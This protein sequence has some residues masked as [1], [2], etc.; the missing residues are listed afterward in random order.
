[1]VS[2][3]ITMIYA[4]GDADG[5]SSSKENASAKTRKIINNDFKTY[6]K[7]EETLATNKIA[8]AVREFLDGCSKEPIDPRELQNKV[9]DFLNR[10]DSLK[11][12]LYSK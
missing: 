4:A 9:N 8:T 12:G 1:M 10:F 11:V 2:V 5:Y 6:E 3:S 7:F